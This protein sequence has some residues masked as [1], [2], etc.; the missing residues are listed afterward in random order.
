MSELFSPLFEISE[1][2]YDEKKKKRNISSK[3]RQFFDVTFSCWYGDKVRKIQNKTITTRTQKQ[4]GKCEG[5]V[6]SAY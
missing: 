1:I 5:I 2:Q 4:N 6:P 3:G